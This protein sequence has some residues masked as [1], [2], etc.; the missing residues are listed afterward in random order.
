MRVKLKNTLKL[1][2]NWENNEESDTSVNYEEACRQRDWLIDRGHLP[3]L[4]SKLS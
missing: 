2:S 1:G 3:F 4:D